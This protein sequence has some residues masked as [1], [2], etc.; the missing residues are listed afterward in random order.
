M[1][2]EEIMRMFEKTGAL[3]RGHFELSS[4]LHSDQY[5]QCALVLQHP[6][7]AVSL[8]GELA[9]KF[10]EDGPDVVVGPALGGIVVSYEVAKAMAAHLRQDFGGQPAEALATAGA[11]SIF[12]ERRDGKMTLRRGF[13]VGT[14]D[15]VLV[16]EVVITTGASVKEIIE[17]MRQSGARVIGVGAICDRSSGP[18]DF[19]ARFESLIKLDIQSFSPRDCPLCKD[20]I[21][22]Q[23]PGSKMVDK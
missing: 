16:V 14:N 13:S 12:C 20:G 7:Y 5:L 1:D 21:P 22:I 3:L 6:E 19:G 17:I 10:K 2:R 23:K 9:S 8:C 15:K 18:I 11:R 4:G